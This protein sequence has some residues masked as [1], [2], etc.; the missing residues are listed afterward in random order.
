MKR[1]SLLTITAAL[2]FAPAPASAIVGGSDAK[3]GEFPSVAHILID[4]AFQCTGTLVTPNHVV[5]AA[6]CD[7]IIPGGVVNVPL[8][9]PGQLIDV[10]VGAMQTFGTDGERRTG[11]RTYVN[12]GWAGIGTFHHDVGIIELSAPVTNKA[13]VKVAGTG[14]ESLWA[15]GTL[16][17]IAGFGATEYGGDQPDTLQKAQVP[18]VQDSVAAAAYDSFENQTQIGA[19]Y[20]EGGVDSC[21]GDSGGPLYV[22]APDGVRLAGDTSYGDGCGEPNKPGIYGRLGAPTLREWVRSIA[23]AAVAGS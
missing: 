21:Q 8:G 17:T 2:A 7:S 23:P 13:P 6:H 16:A 14:E 3:P 4:K 20:P 10:R 19:G 11:K 5:T 12:P 9:Q 22:P 15:P 18:I 1:L